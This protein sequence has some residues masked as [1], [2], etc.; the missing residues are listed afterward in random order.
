MQRFLY[1]AGILTLFLSV[2][3]SCSNMK[4]KGGKH[5]TKHI[6]GLH[7]EVL[8]D[9]HRMYEECLELFPAHAMEYSFRTSKPVKFNIHYHGEEEIYYPVSEEGVSEWKGEFDVGKQKYYTEEQEFFCLMWENPFPEHVNL[10]FE[11]VVRNK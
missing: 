1:T 2:I 9:P 7:E 5:G 11:I 8:I 6:H 3:T 10:F 4:I